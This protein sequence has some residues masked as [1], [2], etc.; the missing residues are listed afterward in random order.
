MGVIQ[1]N[2]REIQKAYNNLKWNICTIL[3]GYYNFNRSNILRTND[4]QDFDVIKNQIK[5]TY[6]V[7]DFYSAVPYW[8]DGEY[9]TIVFPAEWIDLDER[10][11]DL[12]GRELRE[13]HFEEREKQRQKEYQEKLRLEKEYL[14]ETLFD[15]YEAL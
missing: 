6:K 13:K 3:N 12:K 1:M 4:I 5:V 14:L 10:S 2:A 15:L 7:P 11:R 9:N 8:E